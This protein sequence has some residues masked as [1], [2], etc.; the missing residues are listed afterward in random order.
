MDIP[1][2]C[3]V[4]VIGGGP[5][6]STA[7]TLLSQKGYDVVLQGADERVEADGF[8]QKAGGTV[9]WNGVIR[10]FRFRDFGYT[11]PS[12]HVERDL[13]D[14][15]LLDY[16]RDQGARHPRAY[17]RADR[18]DA[19]EISCRFTVDASGQGA[20]IA[21]QLG[22]RVI[23]EGFRFM[24]IWGYFENSRYV[25]ADGRAY[26]F[27]MLPA[28]PPTTFVSNIEGWSWLL[29]RCPN[30]FLGSPRAQTSIACSRRSSSTRPEAA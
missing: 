22:I 30:T 8:V 25:G 9:A 19:G 18:R 15:I 16:A 24:S 7:A 26:P 1:K 20:V 21:R 28:V 17:R 29:P 23:D 13:F 5:G 27:E 3:D 14:K 10:Q 6:G 12:L 2:R 11:R 4:V